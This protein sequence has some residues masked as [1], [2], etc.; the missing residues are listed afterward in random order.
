MYFLKTKDKSPRRYDKDTGN[1][2]QPIDKPVAN[3]Q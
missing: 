1:T 3:L 2:R